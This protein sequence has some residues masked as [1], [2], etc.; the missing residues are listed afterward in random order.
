M[1]LMILKEKSKRNGIS[2]KNSR[3]KFYNIVF[4]NKSNQ[5]KRFNAFKLSLEIKIP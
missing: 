2:N 4:I 3:L 5:L 1:M